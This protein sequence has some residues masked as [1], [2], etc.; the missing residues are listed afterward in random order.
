MAAITGRLTWREIK[1]TALRFRYRW[2]FFFGMSAFAIAVLA[3]APY[4]WPSKYTGTAIFELRMDPAS[5]D[6]TRG[7]TTSLRTTQTGLEHELCGRQAVEQAAEDLRL[8]QGLP[9]GPE[10]ELTLEGEK[11]KQ[12]L[13]QDLQKGL[14]RPRFLAREEG[15]LYQVALSFT[16]TDRD[17]AETMPN[18]LV[19]NYFTN[20]ANRIQRNLAKSKAFLEERVASAD[21]RLTEVVNE[22]IEFEAK[23]AGMMPNDAAALVEQIRT[24]SA[25]A[26]TI[27][28]QLDQDRQ[29]FERLKALAEKEGAGDGEPTQIVK[30][31]NPE[32]AEL[33]KEL[34]GYKE[35]LQ[36]ARTLSH[37]T[38][39]HPTVITLKGKIADLEK[40]IEQTPEET[41]KEK[42]FGQTGPDRRLLLDLA[43]AADKVNS[44]I[45]KL[46]QKETQLKDIQKQHDNY[47]PVRKRWEEITKEIDEKRAEKSKWQS[48][49]TEVATALGAEA[50]AQRTRFEQVQLA[51]KQF[52]PSSPTLLKVLGSALGGGLVFGVALVFLAKTLDHSLSATHEADEHFKLP[53][54]GV[55]GEILM[56]WQRRRRKARRWL[57]E[58]VVGLILLII[59]G[60]GSLHSGLWLHNPDAFEVWESDPIDFAATKVR[61]EVGAV[62]DRLRREL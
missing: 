61:E 41:V 29:E 60:A 30:E 17:L 22:R 4:V 16:H 33:R 28:F 6:L 52:L 18:T 42:V 39:K 35:R 50:A 25:D 19:K 14:A 23:N 54:C 45:M 3:A 11:A 9:R 44:G 43:T 58:P 24:L 8:T 62:V 37:M 26:E 48:R 31:P 57:L 20:V 2:L 5:E 36:N 32:L 40:E 10:G 38:D 51:Q 27:R 15:V 49:L 34:R 47:A 1:R 13:I 56:P 46:K 59:I 12:N 53:V 55:I 21:A 7:R